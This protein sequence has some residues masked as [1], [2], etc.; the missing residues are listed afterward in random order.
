MSQAVP[1]TRLAELQ[2]W[3]ALHSGAQAEQGATLSPLA[4]DAG[5]RRYFRI[6][7]QPGWLAVDAPPATE[8]TAEYLAVA[9]ALGK[10]GLTVPEVS[11]ADCERGF[12][13]VEDLGDKLFGEGVAAGRAD[14]L[15]PAALQVLIEM[16][17]IDDT[18][19]NL[20]AFDREFILRELSIFRQWFVS[21]LLNVT[22]TP[23]EDSQLQQLETL[24]AD[25]LLAQPIV[26]MHRDFHSRNIIE[27]KNGLALI[28]FQDAVRG[29][30]AYDLVSL[31]KDCYLCLPPEKV[32]KWALDYL[33]L[34]HERGLAPH[35]S[36]SDFLQDFDYTGL[37]RHLKVLGIFARLHLRDG[38]SGYLAD[39]PR[40]LDYV[41]EVFDRYRELQPFGQWFRERLAPAYR[42]QSWYSGTSQ[43]G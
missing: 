40:V 37:Q 31:L 9:S 6:A 8:K 41:L 11:A 22:L 18:S 13:L 28:D 5:G 33:A 20:P 23:A 14:Q 34:V 26:F 42:C 15:Y 21:A 32:H 25:R 38:K 43:E 36:E 16:A 29:P 1:D 17:E 30:L 7:E 24:L 19:V 35:L 2:Q 39:L 12:L 4:G 3:V 27:A 10:A